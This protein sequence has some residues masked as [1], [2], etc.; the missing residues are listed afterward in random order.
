MA[1]SCLSR[2]QLAQFWLPSNASDMKH[3]SGHDQRD[4]WE[5]NYI[6]LYGIKDHAAVKRHFVSVVKGSFTV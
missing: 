4:F 2:L 3:Q 6:N 5:E 1:A